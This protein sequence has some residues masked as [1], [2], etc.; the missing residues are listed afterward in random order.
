MN[1]ATQAEYEEVVLPAIEPASVYVDKAGPEILQQMYVF[2]D[3]SGRQLCLRPEGQRP[4]NYS[5]KAGKVKR[6]MSKYGISLDVGG[7]NVHKREDIENLHSLAL[8]YYIP[9]MITEMNLSTLV[10]KW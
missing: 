7:M 6:K 10:N 8:K 3:R 2:P 9:E 5:L 1:L 4:C